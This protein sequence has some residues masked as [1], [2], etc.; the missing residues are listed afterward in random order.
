M[1]TGTSEQRN[2][3]TTKRSGA[4]A[5][6][7]SSNCPIRSRRRRT[8]G[9]EEPAPKKR[10]RWP[11]VL[12]AIGGL[13]LLMLLWLVVTAPL[14]RA[15]EPLDDPAM[16]LVSD[17]GQA[18]AR[19]GAIKE[20]PV[21]VTKLKPHTGRRLRRDRGPP[22]LPPLGHRPARD[23]ARA[24]HQHERRRGA[25]RRKHDHPATRQDQF[26][27]ERPHLPPQGAGSDH[28][29]LARELA[30]QGRNPLAL[31][32]ER[33]F[34]RRRLRAARRGATLF[35][36]PAGESDARPIGDAGGS[37][38]GAVAAGADPQSQPA[39]RSAAGWC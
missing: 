29:L 19:R 14:S 25:P 2:W 12:Y 24:L 27:V 34:R 21:D 38:S 6:C 10:R 37:G 20:A 17:D 32:V 1:E 39:R 3:R 30:D 36:S 5:E 23:R 18:I 26:P 9:R 15:L 13:F 31:S 8:A 33:L 28:R 4:A 11:L 35:R 16:L 22:L 7:R